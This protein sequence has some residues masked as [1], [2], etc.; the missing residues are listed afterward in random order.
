[1]SDV[2]IFIVG[3]VIFAITVYGVVIAGGLAMQSVEHAENQRI[4]GDKGEPPT[5]VD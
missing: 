2:P 1:M 4:Y 5:T 3:I